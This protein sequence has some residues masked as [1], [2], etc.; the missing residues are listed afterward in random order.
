VIISHWARSA[1]TLVLIIGLLTTVPGADQECDGCACNVASKEECATDTSGRT[2]V[3]S[4]TCTSGSCAWVYYPPAD[5]YCEATGCSFE[6]DV[7][8][9]GF[10]AGETV[11]LCWK[12]S[13]P[14]F[15]TV[16]RC[17]CSLSTD[18]TGSGSA[19][20]EYGSNSGNTCH[21]LKENAFSIDIDGVSAAV[22]GVECSSCVG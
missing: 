10:D 6:V 2:V 16:E 19:S 22:E 3:I 7:S 5:P 1:P 17:D 11:D 4:A 21:D 8:W 18:E 13:V 14:P 20:A 12:I 15:T 9:S